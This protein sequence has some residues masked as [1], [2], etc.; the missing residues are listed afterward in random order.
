MD[1]TI[2]QLLTVGGAAGALGWV[3][4]LLTASKPGLHT[5]S[6]VR[7]LKQDKVDLLA[8]VKTLTESL[9]D[10]NETDRQILAQLKEARDATHQ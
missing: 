1:A 6:E 3:L 4:R 8:I 10:S 7:G 2:L 5:A 9:R